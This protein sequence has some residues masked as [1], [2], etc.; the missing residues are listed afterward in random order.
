MFDDKLSSDDNAEGLFYIAKKELYS[1]AA[2]K[3][4]GLIGAV[5]TAPVSTFRCSRVRPGTTAS[6]RELTATAQWWTIASST[7]PAQ[8]P[9]TGNCRPNL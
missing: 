1:A 3:N 5:T 2:S 4:K 7:T 9:E 8:H 6:N